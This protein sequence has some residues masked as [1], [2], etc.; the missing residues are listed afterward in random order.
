MRVLNNLVTEL[1]SVVD[2][3]DG[4]DGVLE[5]I[6]P[7]DR[8]IFISST[9]AVE[10]AE[11]IHIALD[12]RPPDEVIVHRASAPDTLE[13]MRYLPAGEHRLRIWSRG[14]PSLTSLVVRAIPE[15]VFCKFQ[16]DPH[17]PEYGPYDWSFLE[18]HVLSN[19]NT[20]VGSGDEKH[21][22]YLVAWK[23]QGK[24]WI[25]E[26]YATPYFQ[27]WDA[28]EAYQYWLKS[29]GLSNPLLD[30][31]IVDEFFAGDDERYLSITESIL[32]ICQDERLK[33]KILYPYCGSMYGAKLSEEFVQSVIDS[34]YRVAWER[35]LREQPDEET[36]NKFLRAKLSQE[37]ESW[38]D[39]FP[40]CAEHMIVCLGY[41]TITE[42]LNIDPRVD[43]KVWMDMQFHHLAND[44]AFANLYGLME[45]TC[46]YADE[47]TVRWAT[48][49]YRH[50]ALEGQRELLSKQYGFKY[51]LD[52]IRNPD[53]GE[54]LSEWTID[55]AEEGSIDVRS[56]EGYSWLQGRYPRTSMGDTFLWTKRSDQKR[57]TFGQEIRNMCPGSIYSL[58]MITA[59]YG[60]LTA[61]RSVRQKHRIS[62]RIDGAELDQEK[63]FQSVVANNYAHKLGAFTDTHKAWLNYHWK[64]FRANGPVAK[65]TIS[66]WSG[67]QEFAGPVGQELIYNLIEVQP[68]WDG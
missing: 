54:G 45:Y 38:E 28:N 58:K 53:F 67:E 60:D 5:F 59:D 35:Y 50:Y 49:L 18:K 30:G 63:S 31:I 27:G 12:L 64:V 29:V 33:G 41:M 32:R 40:G 48:R 57:N 43:Y 9:A 4:T 26:V 56:M 34:G 65:L 61:G 25:E 55:P 37:M 62:V 66:D 14:K 19:T 22:P 44:P 15:L 13:A 17:I 23:K 6:N 3:Q 1:L 68:Y 42:S 7:R 10:G 2:F 24:R 52:H 36:A 39:R 11:Q 20:I 21:R 16:Y 47:E 46:G 51:Q 8:W